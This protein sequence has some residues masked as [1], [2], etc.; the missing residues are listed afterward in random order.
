MDRLK[1]NT[2]IDN[3]EISISDAAPKMPTDMSKASVEQRI[4]MATKLM[5]DALGMSV[6]NG[7]SVKD[8]SFN[9]S[10]L[11]LGISDINLNSGEYFTDMITFDRMT[12]IELY[13][14]NWIFRRIIDRV[15]QDMWSHGIA[16]KSD[17][18]P[19]ELENVYKRLNRLNSQLIYGREQARLFGGAASLIMVDDGE[20]DLSK[21]LNINNIKPHSPIRLYTTDRWY[22][23]ETSTE[24]VTNF[25]SVDF[26]TPKYYTFY[27]DNGDSK[28]STQFTRVHHS[29]VLRHTNRRTVRMME[30]RLMGWGLSELEHIYQTLLAHTT[31]NMSSVSLVGKSLLE[32]IKVSGMR[33]MMSGLS[34]GNSGA[35]AQ[36]G[37]Q[38]SAINNYRNI[39]DLVLIDKDDEYDR[40]E[41]QLNGLNDLLQ[42]EQELIAGAAEMPQVLIYGQT[43]NGLGDNATE[44]VFYAQTIL[45]KQE[46]ELRV[47]LDKLLPIIFKVEGLEVPKDLDYD[48]NSINDMEPDAKVNLINSV[49]GAINTLTEAGLM[50]KETGLAE[51]KQYSAITGFGANLA[52]RDLELAKQMDQ[53][54]GEEDDEMSGMNLGSNEPQVGEEQPE[55]NLTDD[56]AEVKEKVLKNKFFDRKKRK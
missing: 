1:K 54:S 28:R 31:M 10:R 40:K 48:F 14:G 3:I 20:E 50:T 23:L 15:A 17:A 8:G 32:I 34:M 35:Q 51:L 21:P 46:A 12:I 25:K 41:L 19:V 16:I 45:G 33:G 56:Y 9:N 55:D 26:N 7:V 22:G 29:R 36:L 11:K 53:Q 6:S 37:A 52:E 38:L 2:L 30:D 43:K 47:E 4:K 49:A 42:N 27:L 44:M 18:D 5:D 39:N 13:H 24:L